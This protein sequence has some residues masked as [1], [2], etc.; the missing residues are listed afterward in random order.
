M[1]RLK[2]LPQYEPSS[3]NLLEER[4]ERFGAAKTWIDDARDRSHRQDV[5]RSLFVFARQSQVAEAGTKL[6]F[7]WL[8]GMGKVLRFVNGRC[9]RFSSGVLL[10]DLRHRTGNPDDTVKDRPQQKEAEHE[11]QHDGK[12]ERHALILRNVILDGEIEESENGRKKEKAENHGKLVSEIPRFEGKPIRPVLVSARGMLFF[13]GGNLDYSLKL[14]RVQRPH[15]YFTTFSSFVPGSFGTAPLTL[16]EV[17]WRKGQ[18][19]G[20]PE[21]G[22]RILR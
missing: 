21:R 20:F 18:D 1:S 22:G 19:S 15:F 13:H 4:L 12:I 10:D 8:E 2:P 3:P 16:D 7:Q 17:Y 14:V 5:F 11:Q 9:D 6:L